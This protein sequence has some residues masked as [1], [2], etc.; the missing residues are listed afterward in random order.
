LTDQL[1]PFTNPE[2][3]TADPYDVIILAGSYADA[4]LQP[5]VRRPRHAQDREA[6]I[7]VGDRVEI[8]A[9]MCVALSYDHPSSMAAKP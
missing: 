2:S 8:R 5:A 4:R 1:A 7:A 9:M 6:P 3:V